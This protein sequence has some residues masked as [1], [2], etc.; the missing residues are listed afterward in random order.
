MGDL[1]QDYTMASL[2]RDAAS[3]NLEI[4]GK[5]QEQ[6]L[7]YAELLKLWNERM[8]LTSITDLPNI[9][10]KHFLDSLYMVRLVSQGKGASRILDMGTGAGFPGI[11]IN[12]MLPQ[13]QVTLCDSLQKRTVF[14][15]EVQN[16]LGLEHVDIVH[17]RAEELAKDAAYRSNF[18]VVTAR[19]VA[20]LSTLAE[21]CLPF[22]S[23]D[24]IFAAMKGPDPH[25]EVGQADQALRILGGKVQGVVF[26]DLPLD[27]GARTI[28][29]I[30]KVKPTPKSFPRKP[31]E[32]I[33]H[34]LG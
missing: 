2:V 23:I 26:Y 30:K 8:N 28:V 33:R 10:V 13:Y 17:S 25:E 19:A 20:K 6:F 16:S 9:F 22:V 11:V 4:N 14:L 27:A 32:A 15:H 29:Q 12:I 7:L 5:Q 1:V 31:G 24:G 18:H 34:P 3:L 21:W